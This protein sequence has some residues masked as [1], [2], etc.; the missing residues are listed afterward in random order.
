MTRAQTYS[1]ETLYGIV[2]SMTLRLL[3]V[4]LSFMGPSCKDETPDDRAKPMPMPVPMV[5]ALIDAAPKTMIRPEPA[6]THIEPNSAEVETST[7]PVPQPA[8]DTRTIVDPDSSGARTGP[9]WVHRGPTFS[10]DDGRVYGVGACPP[11]KNKFLTRTTAENRARFALLKA[12]ET[13]TESIDERGAKTTMHPSKRIDAEILEHWVD[14][15]TQTHFALARLTM[16][17]N[18]ADGRSSR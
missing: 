18:A 13:P 2:Q 6:G 14:P 9:A 15:R 7:S 10:D 4:L 5:D 8:Q 11:L 1:H 16:Q 17:G 3:F 12:T